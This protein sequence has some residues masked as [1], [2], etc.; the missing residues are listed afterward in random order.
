MVWWYEALLIPGPL[1]TEAYARG[2]I[3][4]HIPLLDEEII[5]ERV[6]AR[7]E[8]QEIHTRRPLVACS[9]VLYEAALRSPYVDKEQQ[10]QLLEVGKR[11][12]VSIQVL[13]FSQAMTAALHGAMALLETRD[14]ERLAYTEAPSTSQL[15]ADPQV[16]S[17]Q[18]ERLSMI[19]SMALD[20]EESARFI[21]RMAEDL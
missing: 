2:L 16:V 7:L 12:N 1:Q 18:T 19:R 4:S 13:P 21:E 6:A 10:L 5:D 9:Y 20:P 8:R 17:A 15:T 3:G 14:H 11:H